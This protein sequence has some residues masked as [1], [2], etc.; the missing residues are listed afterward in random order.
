MPPTATA[1]PLSTAVTVPGTADLEFTVGGTGK[2]KLDVVVLYT[3]MD[4]AGVRI[5]QGASHMRTIGPKTGPIRQ[6]LGFD[7]GDK[8][9]PGAFRVKA[10]V[11]E[12]G[13]PWAECIWNIKVQS[14]HAE[15]VISAMETLPLDAPYTPLPD[16]AELAALTAKAERRA[17]RK[18]AAKK[19]ATKQKAAAT[20]GATKKAAA[21][22]APAKKAAT[23]RKAA[24]TKKKSTAKKTTAKKTTA[25]KGAAKKAASK[26]SVAKRG[27]GAKKAGARKAATKKKVAAKKKS[28]R[29]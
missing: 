15:Q 18:Q 11:M 21:K 27:A 5:T 29:R 16:D 4:N 9:V 26:K 6:T 2:G 13:K 1:T 24:A 23:K 22:K 12:D 28:S 19:A 3:V 17:T 20:K 25:K 7:W 14:T 10:T 8:P